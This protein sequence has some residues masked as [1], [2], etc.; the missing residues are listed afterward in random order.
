[1]QTGALDHARRCFCT[2]AR[3]V[4]NLDVDELLPP[5]DQS[6]FEHVEASSHAVILFHGIWAEAPGI[7]SLNDVSVVRH[8]DCSYAWRSQMKMLAAGRAEGLCRTKWVA[9]PERCGRDVEWG[10]HDV[11]PATTR[12]FEIR[13]QWRKLDRTIAYRH[14]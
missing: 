5:G 7:Q 6:I 12:A 11:Y 13:R 1:C 3:S 10:V 4:L 2:Q 8:R 9:V 14:C